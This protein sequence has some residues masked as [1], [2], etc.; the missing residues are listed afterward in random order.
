MFESMELSLDAFSEG[1][2]KE[3]HFPLYNG[4]SCDQI[5]IMFKI[6]TEFQ[7]ADLFNGLNLTTG[8]VSEY[9]S[10]G[11]QV[12]LVENETK[13]KI[14]QDDIIITG[15]NAGRCRSQATAGFLRKHGIPVEH[16]IAGRDSA[17]NYSKHDPILRHPSVNELDA[18]SFHT[19]FNCE[20]LPQVGHHLDREQTYILEQAR[21]YY[22]SFMNALSNRTHFIVFGMSGPVVLLHLLQ[23]TGT[24]EGFKIT[25]FN[26]T[27]T[28][29][30]CS[31]KHSVKAYQTF[32]E[33]LKKHLIL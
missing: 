10:R 19:V 27:D 5:D 12:V 31:D 29:T 23:R 13:I 2:S 32:V 28:I 26:W 9:L 15:C 11:G 22:A 25:Y 1:C 3:Q 6:V 33:Q 7:C 8:H 30:H 21:E 14:N 20:K 24:L 17:I 18:L 16:I 4:L